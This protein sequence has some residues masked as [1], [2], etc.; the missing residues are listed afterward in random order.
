MICLHKV[1]NQAKLTHAF[2]VQK[3][4]ALRAWKEQEGQG[5]LLGDY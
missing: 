5:R 1:Q 4:A 2:E 3:V